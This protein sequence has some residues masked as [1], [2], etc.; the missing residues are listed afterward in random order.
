MVYL[1][2]N[3]DYICFLQSPT[4]KCLCI[5]EHY[6]DYETGEGLVDALMELTL[7]EEL[8]IHLKYTID[9]VWVEYKLQ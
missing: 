8:E 5:I 4:F 7:L 9:A 1:H 2:C 3:I 6:Y